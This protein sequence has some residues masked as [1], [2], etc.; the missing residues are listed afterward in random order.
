[1]AEITVREVDILAECAWSFRTSQPIWNNSTF[2]PFPAYAHNLA[3]A[4]RTALDVAG[5]CPPRWD[6]TVNLADREEV[7]RTN[8]YADISQWVDG[9]WVDNAI[10][11]LIVL[12]GKRIPPQPAL[13]RYLVAH[14][15]GHQV[16][17]MLNQARGESNLRDERL[18]GEYARVRGLPSDS[19]RSG[20][21]GRWHDSAQEI[22]A[23]DFR[24]LVCGIES[25]YW[26]HP[27]VPY[28]SDVAGLDGWWREAVEAI[29][30]PVG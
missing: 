17:W 13:T 1:M 26:P 6:V 27:G 25:E 18:I 7:G 15:Y 11:G 29:S 2:D 19:D 21:G 5:K 20:S 30:E 23:C 4:A 16:W 9:E 12:S 28:P 22:M 8:G 24:I 10:T 3:V 14:E